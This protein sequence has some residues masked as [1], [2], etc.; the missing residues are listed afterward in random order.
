MKKT[1][2]KNKNDDNDASLRN[3]AYDLFTD[4]NDVGPTPLHHK[5]FPEEIFEAAIVS[6]NAKSSNI[7]DIV[8]AKINEKT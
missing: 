7:H 1:T 4:G 6:S 3:K 2:F 5:G 8:I